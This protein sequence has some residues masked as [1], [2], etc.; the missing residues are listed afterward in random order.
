MKFLAFIGFIAVLVPTMI[1]VHLL[2]DYLFNKDNSK[3][4]KP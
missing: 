4:N 1:G 3:G 2:L